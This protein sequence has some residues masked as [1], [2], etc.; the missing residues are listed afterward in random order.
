MGMLAFGRMEML[1]RSRGGRATRKGAYN[2][3]GKV[4]HQRTG[5]VHDYSDREAP[6]LHQVLLPE[7]APADFENVEFLWNAVEAA[8]RRKDAQVAR[9][10][11]LALPAD[12]RFTNAERGE[13][14]LSFAR[15]HFVAKGL[16]VQLDI[17][18]PDKGELKSEQANWHA[19]L[20]ITT[21]RLGP[22]GLDRLKAR[23]LDP[24][25]RRIGGRGRVVEGVLW[26]E[27]WR[28]HQERFCREQGYDLRVDPNG[29]ISEI[30]VG[31]C[32]FRRPLSEPVLRLEA[33]R[34]ANRAATFDPAQVL[35]ALTRYDATFTERDLKRLL[36][37]QLRNGERVK[38]EIAAVRTAVMASPDL[39]VLLDPETKKP[40]GR[41]TTRQVREEEQAVIAAAADLSERKTGGVSPESARRV[42]AR[43]SLRRDQQ[44]AF[45]YA[46]DA[47]RLKLI[48][49]RAGTG[50]SYTLKAIR[51]AHEQDGK[52]VIG[53]A[54][55]NAV[56]RDMEADGFT[57]AATLYSALFKHGTKHW[58]PNTVV[59]VDEAAMIDT[60]VLGKLLA[61][62][63]QANAKLILVGDDRQLSSIERGGMFPELL[64]R[65]A[66]AEL[67]EVARQKVGWQIQAARDLAEYRFN[68]AVSAFERE[69]AISWRDTR[70][71]AQDA[72]V[73]AWKRDHQ[74]WQK[75]RDKWR[76]E[77]PDGPDFPQESRFVFA[78]TNQDVDALN[79]KLRR[80]YREQGELKGPDVALTVCYRAPD[81][82]EEEEL[83]RASFA[84]GDRIQFTKTNHDA[85]MYNGDVGTITH[86][87]PATGA[88][89]ARVDEAHGRGRTVHWNANEF[90]GFRHGYAG[91]IYKGQ[92]KTLDRTYLY[93]SRHWTAAPSYVAL[94]RQR[95]S[96]TIFVSRNTAK[97]A[98]QLAR[99]MARQEI[100]SAS[101]AWATLDE[102]AGSESLD[103]ATLSPAHQDAPP[104]IKQEE[105]DGEGGRSAISNLEVEAGK[106]RFRKELEAR[107]RE[108][109]ATEREAQAR[110]LIRDWDQRFAAFCVAL[111][112]MD[113]DP[114]YRTARDQLLAFA[115]SLQ[116]QPDQAAMLRNASPGLGLDKRTTLLRML[117]DPNPA[118][119]LAQIIAQ[120]EQEKQEHDRRA[121]Q[122]PRDPPRSRDRDPGR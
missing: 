41:F 117:N 46:T 30:H 78:Y 103:H 115:R 20:L 22:H 80:V 62:A 85:G 107:R 16:A 86:L 98:R 61:A 19:H 109:R 51:E 14:A 94:T 84:R 79:A 91:T 35:A 105:A 49:G 71:D 25:V 68:E 40:S 37:K 39:E 33:R 63:K 122:P 12:S 52:Q 102:V 48:A 95:K 9:E 106:A 38:E 7:G 65:H 111:S 29:L 101:I 17:H 3:R 119:A 58:N 43:S 64:Q 89:S 1:Q 13:L 32:R 120:A 76:R 110:G 8:E 70:Q 87:D 27:V 77:H 55:T 56:V 114:A 69:G 121:R 82:G 5:E 118:Q 67:T 44:E 26:G 2:E 108:Q 81:L 66:F 34:S 31:P 96:A 116:E 100:N 45:D 104:A 59:M 10:L 28:A 60:P 57:K 113:S 11:V 50:K 36:F 4:R 112:V 75:A 92:G 24:V 74:A 99:Q 73:A 93:H 83:H 90:N 54:P 53:L 42:K 97:D 6:V 15:E 47:G 23:D 88:I 72:L 18:A 21:R